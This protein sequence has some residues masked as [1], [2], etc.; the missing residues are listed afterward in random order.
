MVTLSSTE[1]EH[2]SISELCAEIMFVK[3]ILDFLGVKVALLII[4]RVDNV[5]AIY[6]TH[7]AVSGPRTKHVDIKYYHV[8]DYIENG[9]VK[10]IL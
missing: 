1:A 2:Y 5:G 7:N 10:T 8:N 4:V 9:I 3:L 6:L